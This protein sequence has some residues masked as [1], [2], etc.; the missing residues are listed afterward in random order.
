MRLL[1]ARSLRVGSQFLLATLLLFLGNESLQTAVAEGDTRTISFHHVHTGEDITITYKV[2]GRYDDE[3]LKKLDWFMRD[4]RRAESTHMDPHLFD[5]IWETYREVGGREPVQVI[6]GYR[7]PQTNA[8]LRARSS[9]VAEFS[10]HTQGQ[11]MDFYIPGVPLAEIRAVGLRLQRGGVGFYPTSGSPFV[12]LDTGSVRHWPRAS[13]ELLAKIFPNGRTV[14]VPTDGHPFPGYALAL[15]DIERRGGSVS[16]LSLA[17]ARDAGMIDENAVEADAQPKPRSLLADLFGFGK[18]NEESAPPPSAPPV[19]VRPTV[20]TARAASANAKVAAA[21]SVP[22]PRSRHAPVV[23]AAAA[24]PKPVAIRNDAIGNLIEA[25]GL[26]GAPQMAS[27]FPIA[28]AKEPQTTAGLG[29]MAL[30][31]AAPSPLPPRQV[32]AAS[33]SPMGQSLPSMATMTVVEQTGPSTSVVVR[34]TLAPLA[35]PAEIRAAAATGARFDQPWL[36]AAL[37]APS[38]TRALSTRRVGPFDV[39]PLSEFY[40]KPETSVVMGFVSDPHYGMVTERFTGSAVVFLAT[41]TFV[42][43]PRTAALQ[44]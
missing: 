40:R 12:H 25:R 19:R 2:N 7:S 44:R 35:A 43:A 13:R 16:S 37:L 15:A 5:V 28:P 32:P 38:V 42:P 8:M 33:A 9:G 17:S 6:C 34:Q 31:Y 20:V 18:N 4:W 39:R 29:T 27:S 26:W 22:L 36:R 14:H 1:T 23:L 30:A 41:A 10:E 11:A 24:E 21:Q 3:A